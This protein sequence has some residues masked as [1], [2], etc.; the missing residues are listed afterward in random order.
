MQFVDASSVIIQR[1]IGHENRLPNKEGDD[2]Y[3][4]TLI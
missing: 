1:E 2:I 3:S 4:M